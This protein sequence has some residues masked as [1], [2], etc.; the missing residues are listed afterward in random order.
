MLTGVAVWLV[1]EVQGQLILIF[2]GRDG[3]TGCPE[4]ML[5]KR[6]ITQRQHFCDFPGVMSDCVVQ[7]IRSVMPTNGR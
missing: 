5:T 6:E 4:M 7:D 1:T 2:M 3:Q